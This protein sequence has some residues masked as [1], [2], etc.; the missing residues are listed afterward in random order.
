[1]TYGETVDEAHRMAKDAI[2][3]YVESLK[4]HG[5]TITDDAQT[6]DAKVQIAVA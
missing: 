5:E 3:A 6:L 1:M 2:E 4:E